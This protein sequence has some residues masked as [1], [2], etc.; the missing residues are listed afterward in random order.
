MGVVVCLCLWRENLNRGFT[1]LCLFLV[2]HGDNP[3]IFCLLVE[4][5]CPPLIAPPAPAPPLFTSVM[6]P[7]SPLHLITVTSLSSLLLRS[8][9][10]CGASTQTWRNQT[11]TQ[12]GSPDHLQ[13][14]TD[15]MRKKRA[16]A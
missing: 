13:T 4:Y 12:V 2:S 5:Q 3:A 8:C 16:A 14:Q 15:N 10:A 6:F 11:Q 1:V 7:R 9:Q